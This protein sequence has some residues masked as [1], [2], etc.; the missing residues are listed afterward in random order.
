MYSHARLAVW[1]IV[2]AIMIVAL[3]FAYRTIRQASSLH[4]F[5]GTASTIIIYKGTP[6]TGGGSKVLAL[7]KQEYPQVFAWLKASK[8]QH[9]SPKAIPNYSFVIFS[10]FLDKPHH[11]RTCR[12]A[13]QTGEIGEGHTWYFVPQDFKKWL[14]KKLDS[15]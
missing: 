11:S 4:S 5:L 6:E 14:Q 13:S 2:P 8:E 10:T 12:Y 1:L 3:L 7:Q 9:A 15:Q